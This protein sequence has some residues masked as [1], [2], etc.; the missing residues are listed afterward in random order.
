MKKKFLIDT[1]IIIYWLANKYPSIDLRMKQAGRK[2][3]FISSITVAELYFGAYNSVRKEENLGVAEG[4]LAK[5]DI[6]P[7]DE[8]AGKYFGE[9]KASLKRKG[10]I[11]SDS[12]IFIAATAFSNNLILVTNNEEHFGRIKNLTIENWAS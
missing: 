3:V 7:F 12:D 2:S 1:D 5:I 8:K 10:R 4:L 11:I 9:M 6:V